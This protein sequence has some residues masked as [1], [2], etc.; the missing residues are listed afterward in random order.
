MLTLTFTVRGCME[1]VEMLLQEEK[2]FYFLYMYFK[3][4]CTDFPLPAILWVLFCLNDF[5]TDL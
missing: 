4:Y 5:S 3:K 2:P 1:T